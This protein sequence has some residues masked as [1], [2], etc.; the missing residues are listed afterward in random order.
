MTQTTENGYIFKEPKT[1]NS[2][3]TISLAARV[4]EKLRRY[5]V[6]KNKQKLRLG[7][8]WE[9]QGR[10]LLFSAWNGSPSIHLVFR[11]IGEIPRPKTH[12]SYPLNKPGGA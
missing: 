11:D 5:R 6:Y 2:I 9:G 10:N 8:K 3:R 12:F 1:K 4:T 7:D